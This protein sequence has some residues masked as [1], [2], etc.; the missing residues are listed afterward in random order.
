MPQTSHVRA[1][2]P[3]ALQLRNQVEDICLSVRRPFALASAARLKPP[4]RTLAE[5]RQPRR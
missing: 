1:A 3:V 4:K 5:Y 2:Q